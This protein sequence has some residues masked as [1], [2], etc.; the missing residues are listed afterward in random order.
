MNK[1]YYSSIEQGTAKFINKYRRR[2]VNVVTDTGESWIEPLYSKEFIAWAD[3]VI[4]WTARFFSIMTIKMSMGL[5][6]Q[7]AM[8]EIWAELRQGFV[9]KR[10][11]EH[12][13][14]L[15]RS[16]YKY[17]DAYDY[18][19]HQLYHMDGTPAF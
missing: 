18:G 6:Y 11:L 4:A 13:E 14:D 16:G 17:R 15:K 3:K 1:N 9:L 10:I 19:P 8:K 2:H 7:E 12:V 5:K